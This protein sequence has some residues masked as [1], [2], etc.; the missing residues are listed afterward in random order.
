MLKGN[1]TREQKTEE[2]TFDVKELVATMN[3]LN[4]NSSSC[5]RKVHVYRK[6]RPLSYSASIL[7]P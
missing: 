1:S 4:E 5:L 2:K 7:E 3:T 6:L